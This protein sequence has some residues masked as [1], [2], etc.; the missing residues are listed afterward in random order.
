MKLKSSDTFFQSYQEV[1]KRL[2]CVYRLA[3]VLITLT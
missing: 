3:L 1:S 2:A